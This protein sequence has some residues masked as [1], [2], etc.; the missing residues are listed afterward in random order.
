MQQLSP[1]VLADIQG[2]I[3]SGYRHLN[4]ARYVFLRIEDA[5]QAR[6]WLQKIVPR[7][8]TAAPWP[9]AGGSRTGSRVGRVKPNSAL[10]LAFTCAGMKTLGAPDEVLLSFTPEF[11]SGI[12]TRARVLG[13]TGP[14]APP[15]WEL[16]GPSLRRSTCSLWSTPSTRPR[17][18]GW[19]AR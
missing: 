15:S 6:L 18:R 12:A 19:L 17:S 1:E 9:V 11:I 2:I 4:F 3:F 10:H 8:A 13:D 7:I 14:S 16:G 5:R